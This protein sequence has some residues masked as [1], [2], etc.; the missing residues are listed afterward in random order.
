MIYHPNAITLWNNSMYSLL[1]CIAD[2]FTTKEISEQLFI[3]TKTVESHR[4][5]LMSK[6]GAKNSVGIVKIVIQKQLL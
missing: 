4:S 1:Q 2:E 3:S 6:L 5:N